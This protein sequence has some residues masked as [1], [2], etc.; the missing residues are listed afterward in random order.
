MTSRLRGFTVIGL[1]LLFVLGSLPEANS[2]CTYVDYT[3]GLSVS[4]LI[5]PSVGGHPEGWAF[6][7]IDFNI[8]SVPAGFGSVYAN[9]DEVLTM[10][11]YRRGSYK[12]RSLCE[13]LDG[14]RTAKAKMVQS[15][16]ATRHFWGIIR[17]DVLPEKKSDLRVQT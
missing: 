3:C 6:D 10:C 17:R 15:I 7:I 16:T 13:A 4:Q 2:D 8:N 12:C 14:A 5:H 11:E 1:S 9:V